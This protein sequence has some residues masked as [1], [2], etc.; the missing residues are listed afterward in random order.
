MRKF[1]IV[2]S[3]LAIVAAAW[4]A[5]RWFKEGDCDARSR[6]ALRLMRSLAVQIETHNVSHG[7]FPVAFTND[8]LC[9][10]P[11]F[12]WARGGAFDGYLRYWS[13][14]NHY[15][16]SY[17]SNRDGPAPT[18]AILIEVRDGEVTSW[19]ACVWPRRVE[20]FNKRIKSARMHSTDNLTSP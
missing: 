5:I 6:N 7:A 11:G 8:K 3:M 15:L 14:G 1:L 13:D 16:I 2:V 17:R 20:A 10:Y 19:P 12:E 18:D 9:S 4:L